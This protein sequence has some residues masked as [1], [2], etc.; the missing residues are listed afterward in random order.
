LPGAELSFL[1]SHVRRDHG[2]VQ[3]GQKVLIT[4]ALDGVGIFVVQLAKTFRAHISLCDTVNEGPG[5]VC[6]RR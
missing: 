3:P 6:R 2:R 4:G 5:P 1:A